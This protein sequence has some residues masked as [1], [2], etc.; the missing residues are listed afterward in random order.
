MTKSMP[1]GCIKENEPPSWLDFNILLETVDLD[2]PIGH[3]FIV[4]IFL[5]E[6]NATEK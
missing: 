2:D 6:K 1:M 3:L 5:N 4:V